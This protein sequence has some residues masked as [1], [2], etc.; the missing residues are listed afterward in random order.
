MFGPLVSQSVR[1]LERRRVGTVT[2][3]AYLRVL[4][5][6]WPAIVLILCAVLAATA[7]A[8]MLL[9]PAYRTS[10]SVWVGHDT[11]GQNTWD[12]LQTDQMLVRTYAE[13]IRSPEVSQTVAAA[14]GAGWTRGRVESNVAFKTI[15]GTHLIQITATG[16][17]PDSAKNL[18]DTYAR[19]FA[20]L[21]GQTAGLQQAR[22]AVNYPAPKPGHPFKPKPKLY[23]GIGL[24]LG[25]VAGLGGA[26]LIE[27]LD[28]RIGTE[29][30]AVRLLGL[31]VVGRIP[32]T[33]DGDAANPIQR[34]AFRMLAANLRFQFADSRSWALGVTSPGPQEG[35]S[36]VLGRL[37]GAL[38]D[39]GTNV[40]A[41]D[42]DLRRPS[43]HKSLN[44]KRSPGLAEY[45]AFDLPINQF[46]QPSG[47]NGLAVVG[48]GPSPPNPVMFLESKRMTSLLQDLEAIASFVLVDTPPTSV[49]ADAAIVSSKVDSMI[50]V[51]DL[52]RTDR[53]QAQRC[54]EQLK[55]AG[56]RIAGLVVNG[57]RRV[58]KTT[59]G[60]Y[61]GEPKESRV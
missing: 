45:L 44:V 6:R 14:M 26:L 34:E 54:L 46:L 49:A 28:H 32:Y 51:V 59:Y 23:G 36:T 11:E 60:E 19:V 10:T 24:F 16:L 7:A 12:A 48:A 29:E 55:Q 56:A 57:G 8:I 47:R 20:S 50:L 30:E 53:L 31:P 25:L 5:R 43:L 39:M 4:R 52:A 40:V 17:D 58:G 13:L 37:A 22:V 42:A 21:S 35:K 38:A 15:E 33:K 9:P 18:A 41:V 1:G 61:Y 3:E 27:R 2:F